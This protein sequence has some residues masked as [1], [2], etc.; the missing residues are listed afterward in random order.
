M[1]AEVL[2][3]PCLSN[4]SCNWLELRV[5]APLR[6][7][8]LSKIHT[9]TATIAVIGLGYVG[10]PLAVAFAERGFP[11]VGSDVAGRQVA[12]LNRARG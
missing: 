4:A 12:A 9:R 11:V 10:L 1:Q 7:L 8:L 3:Y 5:W 6:E 2:E